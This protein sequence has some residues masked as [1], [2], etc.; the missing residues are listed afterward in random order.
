ME[1]NEINQIESDTE[2]PIAINSSK[3][4]YFTG[5]EPTKLAKEVQCVLS[6]CTSVVC[7]CVCACSCIRCCVCVYVHH[8]HTDSLIYSGKHV[9]IT[10]LQKY[11]HITPC[12][13]VEPVYKDHQRDQDE[14]DYVDKWSLCRDFIVCMVLCLLYG[15][16]MV[17]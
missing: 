5:F 2:I 4:K 10:C 1:D 15:S 12:T 6:T 3:A 8:Q 14:V 11:T 13:T 16:V 9:C 17:T 7:M